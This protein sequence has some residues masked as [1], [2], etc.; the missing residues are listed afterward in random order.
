MKA[1]PPMTLSPLYLEIG[2]T[3]LQALDGDDGFEIPLERQENGRL[4]AASREK[5]SAGARRHRAHSAPSEREAFR[6]GD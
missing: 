6:C 2:L 5:L 4:T 1:F 3:S